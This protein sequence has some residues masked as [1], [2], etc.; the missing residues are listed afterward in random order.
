M[1]K[2][3][4]IIEKNEGDSLGRPSSMLISSFCV[5]R[6]DAF[7]I[8]HH[9]PPGVCEGDHQRD[10]HEEQG[11]VGPHPWAGPQPTA[12]RMGV[13]PT[14]YWGHLQPLVSLRAWN[15]PR[16]PQGSGPWGSEPSRAREE[17]QGPP[18]KGSPSVWLECV[19]SPGNISTGTEQ[20]LWEKGMTRPFSYV[21]TWISVALQL[22]HHPTRSRD[23][24][25]PW[26]WE[27]LGRMVVLLGLYPSKAERIAP[28]S[29]TFWFCDVRGIEKYYEK[30]EI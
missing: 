29:L 1:V 19:D 24:H 11:C 27:G 5:P 25:L 2:K 30:I 3:S 9:V 7:R 16:D 6:L 18:G 4:P 23:H 17:N 28:V 10:G 8:P 13:P 12:A 21:A 22:L 26:K 15:S 14:H 20:K